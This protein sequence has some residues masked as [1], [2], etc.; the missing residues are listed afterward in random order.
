LVAPWVTRRPGGFVVGDGIVQP[1]NGG[2]PIT[3][4][5]PAPYGYG[6]VTIGQPHYVGG[7]LAPPAPPAVPVQPA[8]CA[9]SEK[10]FVPQ[11]NGSM[12]K[13][14]YVPRINGGY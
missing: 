11:F 13:P 7:Q 2:P 5:V 14:V 1:Y 6:G 8:W 3:Y 4:D 9:D 12:C 10:I